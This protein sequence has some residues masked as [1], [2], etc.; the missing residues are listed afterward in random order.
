MSPI[1]MWLLVAGMLQLQAPQPGR[2]M[3]PPCVRLAFRVV[4]LDTA[5]VRRMYP[6]RIALP[7][8]ARLERMPVVRVRPCTVTDSSGNA[9]PDDRGT[10]RIP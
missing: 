8:T 9:R 10:M 5:A 7:D 4:P 6:M 1:A 3:T 2:A